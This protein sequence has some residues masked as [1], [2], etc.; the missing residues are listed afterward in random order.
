MTTKPGFPCLFLTLMTF[1]A[2]GGCGGSSGSGSDG[3]ADGRD[4]GPDRHADVTET[5]GADAAGIDVPPDQGQPD[6]PVDTAMAPDHAGGD[7][8][9]GDSGPAGD[10]AQ[11]GAGADHADG[12]DGG[13]TDVSQTDVSETGDTGSGGPTTCQNRTPGQAFGVTYFCGSIGAPCGV[14]GQD[15]VTA[16]LAATT[17]ARGCRSDNLCLAIAAADGAART[18]YCNLAQGIGGCN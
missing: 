11:D 6:V 4:A 2:A 3:P 17:T 8:G 16:Y 13:T 1:L 10:A 18:M 5:G 9:A 7:T 12:G 15:C 14:A